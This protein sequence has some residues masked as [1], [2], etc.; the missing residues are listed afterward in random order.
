MQRYVVLQ[1]IGIGRDSILLG[2][3]ARALGIEPF[4]GRCGARAIAL[5]GELRRAGR[6]GLDAEKA[7]HALALMPLAGQRDVR[8]A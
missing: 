3:E 8:V 5:F 6:R 1:Q 4:Q 7:D 2:G